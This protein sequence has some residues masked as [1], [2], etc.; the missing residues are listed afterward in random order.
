MPT[1]WLFLRGAPTLEEASGSARET[2]L[3][4]S[5]EPHLPASASRQPWLL[6]G[7]SRKNEHEAVAGGD[8]RDL[9]IEEDV[10]ADSEE[11]S[12]CLQDEDPSAVLQALLEQSR[13][14]A[15][16]SQSNNKSTFND[17]LP[18][19][20]AERSRTGRESLSRIDSNQESFSESLLPPPTQQRSRL[21]GDLSRSFGGL[22]NITE[23]QS[24]LNLPSWSFTLSS[25]T[26][27]NALPSSNGTSAYNADRINVLAL[28]DELEMPSTMPVK[29]KA[30]GGKS[31]FTRAGMTLVDE[32]GSTLQVVMWDDYAEE[33]AGKHLLQGDVVYVERIAISQYKGQRQGSTVSGSKVQICY[34]TAKRTNG[35]RT[36]PGLRPQLDLDWDPVSQRVKA[37]SRLAM[38][39]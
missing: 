38:E 2:L 26:S 9:G 28:I 29:N 18:L 23:E 39:T 30:Q 14:I 12:T 20:P 17:Y 7:Q 1:Q 3:L 35:R 19:P 22:G 31:E 15:E 5:Q 13:A 4:H 33:W 32:T 10:I 8:E 34:R 11:E 37:L 25:L 27:L 6:V 16:E 24:L 21:L 36:D